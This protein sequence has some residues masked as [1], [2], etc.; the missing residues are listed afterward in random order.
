MF[1]P[2]SY[3]DLL[4]L[5]L[6]RDYRF[7]AF[8]D[9]DRFG[10]ERTL[11][12]RHDVDADLGCALE[13]ARIEAELGVRST[14]FVMLRSPVYNLHGRANQR[15][16][17]EILG[18]GH[19]LGLHHDG[20]FPPPQGR[21]VEEDVELETRWL[22]AQFGAPV[23]AVSFHQPGPDV[24]EGR[25]QLEGYV[26][27]YDKRDLD[28]F[29]YVSDSNRSWG[30]LPPDQLLASDDAPKVHLLVHPMWWAHAH[31]DLS[32]E[33]VWDRV[34]EASW[35]RCQEQMLATERAYGDA[36]AFRIE[37]DPS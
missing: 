28:G 15:L 23:G 16:L 17:D 26:N 6:E 33:E 25:V 32:T 5:A 13:L 3:R 1:T 24:L 30:D 34:V 20:N 27:T 31:V 10:E 36:R 2:S 11:L 22:T 21:S 4:Q 14:Y 37:R 18:L 19:W 29:R 35:A 7:R 9:P 8:D 12:L